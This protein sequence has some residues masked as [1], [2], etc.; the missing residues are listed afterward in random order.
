MAVQNK[1][2]TQYSNPLQSPYIANPPGDVDGKIR[3][4]WFD[5]AQAT[6][7]DATS[8]VHLVK[9]PPGRVRVILPLSRISFSAMGTATTLDLGWDAYRD[10]SN[11]VVVADADGLAADLDVAAAGSLLFSSS[12]T[13]PAGSG[14]TKIFESNGGINLFATINDAGIPA[15]ATLNGMIAWVQA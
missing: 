6:V 11:V 14:D 3:I 4:A 13:L 1:Q 9:L 15:A 7:G 8:T 12:G 10:F 2:S 5:H